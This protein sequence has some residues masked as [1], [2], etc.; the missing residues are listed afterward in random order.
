MS[1]N[2]SWNEYS[3][4][5]VGP[6]SEIFVTYLEYI[7]LR[8]NNWVLSVSH[9]LV[10][11]LDHCM[12]LNLILKRSCRM[13]SWGLVLEMRQPPS[14]SVSGCGTTDA[15][16]RCW[17]AGVRP[18]GP[19]GIGVSHESTRRIMSEVESETCSAFDVP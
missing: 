19:I 3:C 1:V 11:Y 18:P 2:F 10:Y 16:S 5:W 14:A 4:P 7:D 17:T 15:I 8:C 9:V 13:R 6:Y 12:L